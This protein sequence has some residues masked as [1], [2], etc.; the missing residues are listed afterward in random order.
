MASKRKL[1]KEIITASASLFDEALLLR[2]FAD[3]EGKASIE[4]IM[5]DIIVFTDDSLRRAHHTDG[6]DNPRL[7]RAYYRRLRSDIEIA[8]EKFDERLTTV[9]EAL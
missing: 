2:L 4:E 9:L 7:V 5:D 3:A 6:A 1:K 8:V